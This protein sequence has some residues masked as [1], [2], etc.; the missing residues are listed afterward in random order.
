M[1]LSKHIERIFLGT[2]DRDAKDAEI[3][4]H[5]SQIAQNTQVVQSGARVITHMSEMM[6]LLAHDRK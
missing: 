5:R 1:K 6:Q 2:Y 3:A 4:Y